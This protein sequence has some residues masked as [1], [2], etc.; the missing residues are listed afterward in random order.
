MLGVALKIDQGILTPEP[1]L[2]N[3]V[4]IFKNNIKETFLILFCTLTVPLTS[5]LEQS[6]FAT[7]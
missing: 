5:S 2:L 4:I 7:H 3:C 1:V 6:V